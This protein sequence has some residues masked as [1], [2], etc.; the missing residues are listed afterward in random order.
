MGDLK[1]NRNK[2]ELTPEEVEKGKNFERVLSD[3][4]ARQTPFYKTT[5]FYLSVAVTGGLIAIGTMLMLNDGGGELTKTTTPFIDPMIPGLSVNDTNYTV[6]AA[7]GAKLDYFNGSQIEIPEGAFLDKN[8]Q[9][10]TGKVEIRYREYHDP[11]DIVIAGI[12]MTYDSAGERRHFESAGMFEIVAMKDGEPLKISPSRP[13]K[14]RMVSHTDEPKFNVYYLDTAKKNWEYIRKDKA[15]LLAVEQDSGLSK[16]DSLALAALATEPMKPQKANP[17]RPSFNI[18]VNPAEFPE[19]ALYEGILFEVDVDKTPYDP[20]LSKITW[21][22]AQI[23]RLMNTNTY[24]V[25]FTKGNQTEVFVTYAV[26][27]GKDFATAM[28]QYDDRYKAYKETLKMR[29]AL[30][31]DKQAKLEKQLVK[32]DSDRIA[33]NLQA[34]QQAMANRRNFNT[35]SEDV[36]FRVFIIDKFG[37]W[38]SDCPSSLPQGVE[39]AVRL[40]NAANNNPLVAKHIYLVEKSRNAI[41]TY[42]DYSLAN[43]KYNPDAENLLWCITGDNK[44][45]V[46][47]PDEFDRIDTTKKEVVLKLKVTDKKFES[48][49][50]AKAFLNI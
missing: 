1:I 38:N 27:N 50:E 31:S 48:T 37:I 28:K 15:E 11:G 8:G 5:K 47:Q 16:T 26:V 33:R 4:A 35:T 6:D 22:D 10:V 44:I 23:S 29:K 25:R 21:E 34:L 13:I 30:E 39:L 3:Y 45:A 32:M 19:L 41:F 17:K 40:Q 36:V 42:Y 2:G 9:P 24:E 46:L 43:F 12:P 14:V 49:G 20:A 18:A 7:S